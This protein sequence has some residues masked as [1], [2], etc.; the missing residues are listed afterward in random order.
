MASPRTRLAPALLPMRG[1]GRG[2][3]TNAFLPLPCSPFLQGR[4]I[5]LSLS[6]AGHGYKITPIKSAAAGK[7]EIAVTGTG[8]VEQEQEPRHPGWQPLARVLDTTSPFF[9]RFLFLRS[10]EDFC[11]NIYVLMGDYLTIEI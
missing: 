8:E 4:G 6:L 7:G 5:F 10:F 11:S 2:E 9:E 1:E 3:R